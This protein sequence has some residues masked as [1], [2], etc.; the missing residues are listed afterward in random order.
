MKESAKDILAMLDHIDSINEVRNVIIKAPFSYVGNKRQIVKSLND[1]MPLTG[2]FIDV[3]GGS[4]IVTINRTH[5]KFEVFNDRNSGL[6]DCYRAIKDDLPAF[7]AKL[8]EL[9]ASRELWTLF[10]EADEHNYYGMNPLERA[11]AW[12]Y[13]HQNSFGGKEDCFG[14]DLKTTG[15]PHNPRNAWKKIS[16]RFANVMIENIPWE[17][18]FTDF[19]APNSVFYCDPPYYGAKMY[20]H[21]FT[22]E[23]HIRLLDTIFSAEGS[24]FLSGYENDI[25]NE[26]PWDDKHYFPV[27]STLSGK[28]ISKEEVVWVKN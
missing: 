5:Q 19:D 11:V 7:L 12:F 26:Y 6:I 28:H 27:Y 16:R 18:C 24:V 2:R 21:H 4:G 9:P 25:Y 10:K 20:K 8:A 13:M 1:L 14:R 15:Q 3:F 23:D 22:N 17:K